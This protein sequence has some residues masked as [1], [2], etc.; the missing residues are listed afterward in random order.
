MGRKIQNK[1]KVKQLE[2]VP[3]DENPPLPAQRTSED[4]V[5]KRVKKISRP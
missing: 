5:P 2:I 1:K 3:M 4:V